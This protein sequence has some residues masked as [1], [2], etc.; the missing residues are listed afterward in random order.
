MANQIQGMETEYKPWGGLAGIMAGNRE[1]NTEAANL[2]TLQESQL[3]NAIKGVEAGRAVS[4][5]NDP[6]MEALRQGGI[7]GRNQVDIAQGATAAGTQQS[8]MNAKIAENL[9]KVPKAHVEKALA[10]THQQTMGLM[11]LA[12][13]LEQGGGSD[14]NFVTKAMEMAPQLGMSPQD[15]QQLFSNPELLKKKLAQNQQILTMVPA[16]LQKMEEQ[17]ANNKSHGLYITQPEIAGREKANTDDNATQLEIA[18]MRSAESNS[19]TAAIN[20]AKDEAART[21]LMN[22]LNGQLQRNNTAIKEI[23]AEYQNISPQSFR[24]E[25]VNGKPL[26]KD[27]V[28]KRVSAARAKLV[29]ERDEVVERSKD[30]QKQLDSMFSQSKFAP[31]SMFPGDENALAEDIGGASVSKPSLPPGVTIKR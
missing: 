25:L 8:D 16:V 27:E 6:R 7:M 20:S 23:E 1:I 21:N 5:Y 24:G 29:K 3:G 31:K 18:A 22:H 2:Q 10:E 17:D 26:T 19:N 9:A 12:A 14:L 13:A 30:I 11:G 28:S 4:D 15:L